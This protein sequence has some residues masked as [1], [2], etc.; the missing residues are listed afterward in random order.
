[1]KPTI[2]DLLNALTNPA[3]LPSNSTLENSKDTWKRIGQK[4]SFAELNLDN[5]ELT[6]FLKEWTSEN[7]YNNIA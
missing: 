2:D 6:A 5:S 7:D 4:D 3:S 1:M